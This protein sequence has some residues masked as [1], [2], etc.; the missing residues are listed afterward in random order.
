MARRS[1]LFTPG[2]RPEM[3]RKATG[4]KADVLVFDLEDAV[5]PAR[6]DEARDSVRSVLADPDFNPEAEVCVRV[7]PT[8]V[9]ADEDLD[10]VLSPD[11][12]LDSVM[13][14]KVDGPDD[15]ETLARLLNEHG[16][17][18]PIIAL[19]ETA[20]G[21]L[22]AEAIADADATD[23]LFFGAE[24]LSAD[25]GASRTPEGDE[26]AYARQHVVLA[27][28]AAGIEAID[29]VFTAIDDVDGLRAEARRAVQLGF[30]GKPA[31]HPSQID[32]INEAFI[33]DD[34]ELDWARR[35]LDAQQAADADD[36]GVFAV[37]GQMIDEPLLRR[38]KR[39]VERANAGNDP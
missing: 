9:A 30:D 27:A 38:A 25:I 34:E 12:R 10:G 14:P 15:I 21:V 22:H 32:P 37:D 36:R 31:I 24:D 20:A 39:F 16:R 3:L 8:T 23:A 17:D 18:L 35:V 1:L 5:S 28:A 29:T 6:K 26:V 2:D 19:V 13:L 33:P 4:T 7:N 11:A